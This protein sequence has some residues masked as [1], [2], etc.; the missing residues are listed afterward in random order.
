MAWKSFVEIFSSTLLIFI[1]KMQIFTRRTLRVFQA[2]SHGTEHTHIIST[3]SEPFRLPKRWNVKSVCSDFF[4]VQPQTKRVLGAPPA[5]SGYAASPEEKSATF[6][7][8]DY[9]VKQ[10]FCFR[11]AKTIR[12]ILH[13]QWK[14]ICTHTRKTLHWPLEKHPARKTIPQSIPLAK[15]RLSSI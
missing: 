6:S 9:H 10:M 4:P 14:K 15:D 2:N 7:K 11:F 8:I 12:G 3:W 13:T 1:E 5:A